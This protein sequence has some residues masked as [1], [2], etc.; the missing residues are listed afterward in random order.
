MKRSYR[1][2][3]RD[4]FFK[5]S[6][7]TRL[8]ILIL[9]FIILFHGGTYAQDITINQVELKDGK[10]VVHYDLNDNDTEHQYTL[11]LYTSIDNFVQ[12]M[13][14]VT[15]DIGIAVPVGGNKEVI[16]DARNELDSGFS[17][18]VA[19][20]IKG[21]LYV[22]FISLSHF[23]DIGTF[24]RGKP[25][26]LTWSGGRGDNVMNFDLYHGK[27]KVWTQPNV[28]NSGNLTLVIP[29][30]VKPGRNY[31]FRISDSKDP[32]EVVYTVKFNIKR[33]IPL[34]FKIGVGLIAGGAIG[35]LLSTGT[36]PTES[37]IG[38]PPLP[39]R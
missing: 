17:G 33:K 15:G 9:F 12:P 3:T 24:K 5:I 7:S 10:V 18:S 6:L 34:G 26:N 2:F 16:W 25:Y 30:N 32:D 36:N 27:E 39:T 11:R 8:K 31:I 28:A 13:N 29:T 1:L 38:E 23:E 21:Q 19:L 37:K 20:Q 14:K 35:Y 4:N 22:K